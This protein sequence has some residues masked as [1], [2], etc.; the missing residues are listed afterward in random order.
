M[1][2]DEVCKVFFE[3]NER[4]ADLLNLYTKEGEAVS[5]DD[6]HEVDS[7]LIYKIRNGLSWKRISK[8]RDI[9]RKVVFNTT[10]IIAD[11]EP[12]DNI[13]YS[14]PLR[15]LC[16][17]YGEYEKQ[18][19]SIR[20]NFRKHPQGLSAGEKLYSFSKN[21][22][23]NPTVIILLYSGE[24]K[25]DGPTQLWDMLNMDG[26]PEGLKK[27]VMNHR[28]HMIDIR[29]L[30]KETFR[31]FKTDVGKVFEF[32]S[33]SNSKDEI[34][35]LLSREDY[36]KNTPEDAYELMNSFANISRDINKTEYINDDGGY[37]MCKAFEDHYESGR[38]IG[39]DQG[40]DQGISQG[41]ETILLAQIKDGEITIESAARRL[42]MS[43]DEFVK[44]Y[45]LPIC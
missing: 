40:F 35:N 36:F 31:Q 42:E 20:R 11:I 28:I 1:K 38:K 37:D 29:R 30:Q 12:Q 17:I 24:E 19:R 45:K 44:K 9:V 2:K 43:P 7:G 13:D 3:D 22:K 6:I 41:K 34:D 18:A 32:I 27:L 33:S 15:D 5:A 4:V 23:L 25:W 39:Y 21:S 10:F 14:Y 16:Y 8:S 26:V